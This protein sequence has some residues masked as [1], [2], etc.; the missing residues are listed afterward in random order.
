MKHLFRFFGSKETTW[1]L[2]PSEMDHMLQV[3]RMG[4]GDR[5]EIMDGKGL[6][7][8]ATCLR[9]TKKNLEFSV[10]NE[11]EEPRPSRQLELAV[12]ALRPSTYE[13]MIPPLVEL[14]VT[15]LFIFG[16]DQ[17]HKERLSEKVKDRLH[18]LTIHA[19]K[20]CKSAWLP[21]ILFLE[22]LEDALAGFKSQPICLLPGA[23]VPLFD[24]LTTAEDL[25]GFIIGGEKGFSPREENLVLAFKKA[26]LGPHILRAWTAAVASAAVFASK[27]RS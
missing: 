18:R 23:P 20:Q 9:A 16:Q 4:E 7:A 26:S 13:E 22:S 2:L 6:I 27:H 24:I 25:S 17:V 12:G 11:T 14:G 10:E 3:L 5:F 21:E 15:R 8:T 1:T 19:A